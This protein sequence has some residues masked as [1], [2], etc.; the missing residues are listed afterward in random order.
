MY[1]ATRRVLVCLSIC[2]S[3][4]T[5]THTPRNRHSTPTQS[6]RNMQHSTNHAISNANNKP[7]STRA[8][9]IPES[10]HF[11]TTH[12]KARS[13]AQPR[14][15]SNHRSVTREEVNAYARDF[16]KNNTSD[17][18]REAQAYRSRNGP[19]KPV[20]PSF[21]T[22]AR[23][24]AHVSTT[25]HEYRAPTHP[26]THARTHACTHPRTHAPTHAR[27]HARAHK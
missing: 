16:R 17:A 10:P 18:A 5:L 21:V 12:A 11:G 26:R 24:D 1:T 4:P 8:L 27:T 7:H 15:P 19:T 14:E 20:G 3:V 25:A 22:E 2:L 23:A 13:N 6:R 9:T